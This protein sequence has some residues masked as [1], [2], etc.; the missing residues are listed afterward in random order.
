MRRANLVVDIEKMGMWSTLQ[1][2]LLSP[3]SSDE[4]K[5]ALLWIIGTA[6]QNNP[7]AQ[8]AVSIFGFS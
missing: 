8:K 5:A 7:A 6:A 3:A 4:L 1:G 2:L